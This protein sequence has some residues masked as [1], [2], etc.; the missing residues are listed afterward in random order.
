MKDCRCVLLL[1]ATALLNGCVSSSPNTTSAPS[2]QLPPTEQGRP[3]DLSANELVTVK[4]FLAASLKD[5]L[6]ALYGE[7]QAVID[8]KDIITVCGF[9]NAKNGFGGYTGNKPFMG[10]LSGPKMPIDIF[11]VVRIGG[12]DSENYVVVKLCSD[13]GV[14]M[15]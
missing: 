11:S 8:S 7:M 5:P 14:N 4:K 12:T 9:V 1:I 6:S 13:A 3:Y 10:L 2:N 15:R